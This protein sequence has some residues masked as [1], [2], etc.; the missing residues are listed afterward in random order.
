MTQDNTTASPEHADRDN[1]TEGYLQKPK[2][3]LKQREN[4]TLPLSSSQIERRVSFYSQVEL[5][6]FEFT[7]RSLSSDDAE[8]HTDPAEY[9]LSEFDENPVQTGRDTHS[10][11]MENDDESMELTGQL[12]NGGQSNGGQSNGGQSN[13]NAER[14]EPRTELDSILA[15]NKEQPQELL[16]EQEHLPISHLKPRHETAKS[17]RSS[18]LRNEHDDATNISFTHSPSQERHV[19]YLPTMADASPKAGSNHSLPRPAVAAVDSHSLFK[20][21]EALQDYAD[22]LRDSL[23]N[24]TGNSFVAEEDDQ[25][26]PSIQVPTME[27]NEPNDDNDDDEDDMELTEHA[28]RTGDQV[29]TEEVTMDLTTQFSQAKPAKILE[30]SQNN[31]VTMELT[32]PVSLLLEPVQTPADG[33][34]SSATASSAKI[35]T[36]EQS[37]TQN[38][39]SI[40]SQNMSQDLSQEIHESTMDITAVHEPQEAHQLSIVEEEEEPEDTPMELTQPVAPTTAAVADATKTPNPREAKYTT[41]HNETDVA[42]ELFLTENKTVEETFAERLE[43]NSIVD[44]PAL[45]ASQQEL[46]RYLEEATP[47][48]PRANVSLGGLG[49]P[50]RV[51]SQSFKDLP[52]QST[53]AND[54]ALESMQSRNRRLSD[55]QYDASYEVHQSRLSAKRAL[56]PAI[57]LNQSNPSKRRNTIDSPIEDTEKERFPLVSLT[58]FLDE[59]EVKFFDDLEFANELPI[60]MSRGDVDPG[61]FSREDFYKA[62]IQIPLLEVYELSCKELTGKIGQGKNLYKELQETSAQ[63]VPDLFRKYYSS[64]YYEQ[65]A[66]KSKFQIIRDYTREQAK[67]VWY[68]WRTKLFKN[69]I[70]VVNSN[71]EILKDDKIVLE[72]SI[73]E[74]L[75]EYEVI[76]NRLEMIKQDITRFK[77]IK[78]Q[79]KSL[80]AEEIRTIKTK[81]STLESKLLEHK[82]DMALESGKLDAVN[83]MIT[84]QNRRLQELNQ[85]LEDERAELLKHKHFGNEELEIIHTK[86]QII[87]ACAGLKF[88]ERTSAYT[89]EFEFYPKMGITVDMSKTDSA[90]GLVFHP[91]ESDT[92]TLHNESLERYCQ[93][94]AET[95]PFLNIFETLSVFRSKWL[96][97]LAIDEQVHALSAYYP[98]EIGSFSEE[99]IHFVIQYYSFE[100]GLKVDYHVSI[101]LSRILNYQSAVLVTAKVLKSKGTT[102]ERELR[103]AICQKKASHKILEKISTIETPP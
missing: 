44:T 45:M 12:S 29:N 48:I 15:N 2:S 5:R 30:L 93:A 70:E 86:S 14:T 85:K 92:K 50:V 60:P 99:M 68:E 35:I 24:D 7:S 77:Q 96:Q 66:M 61:K 47:P 52:P 42:R 56:D 72:D 83:E 38:Q 79:H 53:A 51:S 100:T 82:E 43:S 94:L 76:Q 20:P 95:T 67:E 19:L 28:A 18:I 32:Q 21:I 103:D 23:F 17:D 33:H 3:I 80:D 88:I 90:D 73:K 34:A 16:D 59:T 10:E 75:A 84:E 64:S 57:E 46:N 55:S 91:I 78:E 22:S 49:T 25:D 71:L 37:P 4:V 26:L 39:S 54:S 81:L 74:T 87:Q 63:E 1:V 98:I 40:T 97:L 31:E 69:V 101:P 27:R 89:Y 8:G 13:E 65:M 41:P 58:E 36:P 11:E 62:N 9:L 6:Q 102:T